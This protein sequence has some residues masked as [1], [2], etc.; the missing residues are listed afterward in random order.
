MGSI[1]CRLHDG[2]A[3]EF[4]AFLSLQN[5]TNIYLR[6]CH[7]LVDSEKRAVGVMGGMPKDVHWDDLQ[8][9]AA[10]EIENA[11]TLLSFKD[12][13][14]HHRRGDFPAIAVGVSY[15]GGQ[16]VS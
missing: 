5:L 9:E 11:R 15:G 16:S 4:N 8:L 13:E 14:T 10:H 6:T 3:S 12:K 7:P 1:A 2:V